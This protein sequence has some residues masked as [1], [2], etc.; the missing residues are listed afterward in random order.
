MNISHQQPAQPI[1]YPESNSS[2]SQEKFVLNVLGEKLGGT[3]VEIGSQH[4]EISSNTLLL[5]KRFGWSG[6]AIEIDKL[7]SDMYNNHRSSVCVN[8]DALTFDYIEYFE[9]NNFPKQIDY[10][11]ID[12]DDTPRHANLIALTQLPLTRY[13]FSTITIEHDCIR[14]YTLKNMRDAQ[15][16][17]LSSLNY[18]LVV[19][20]ESEDFWVDKMSVPYEKYWSLY[21]VGRFF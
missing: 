16:V 12:V 9:E 6:L 4:P 11:Q 20:G 14:D 5:E 21:T 10:L 18:E 8:A 2:Q 19:Q 1:N 13:R 17:L 15:R 7:Y 3:F